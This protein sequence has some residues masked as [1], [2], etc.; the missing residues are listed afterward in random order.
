MTTREPASL[1]PLCA[2][3]AAEPFHRDRSRDYFRCPQCDLVF[4]PR[5]FHLAP[6]KQKARYDCHR[7]SLAD[8][9]YRAFLN[10]L[11]RPLEK[12]LSPGAQGLD[13]GC[14]RTRTL[15]VL[16][17]AAGHAC[18]DYDLHYADDPAVLDRKYDFLACSETIEHFTRPREEFARLLRLLKPG[19]WLGIMTQLRDE[20]PA[21]ARWFY[22]DDATHVGFFSRKTFLTLAGGAGG[23]GCRLHVEFHP[24]GVVLIQVTG[25]P[26]MP[27]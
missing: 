26:A 14:G 18:A 15:S 23:G 13:F 4:V 9:G 10:R 6:E 2:C 25:E 7:Q 21:F 1:C 22:K 27:L 3:G 24:D 12:K 17:E 19:G 20:A 8:P 11:F 5:T 16:F